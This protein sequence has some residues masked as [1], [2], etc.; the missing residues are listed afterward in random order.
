MRVIFRL[1]SVGIV[2]LVVQTSACGDASGPKFGP[3]ATEV[4]VA[5]N[6]QPNPVVG[7]TLPIPLSIR[8]ADQ[9]DRDVQGATVVWSTSSGTLSAP[10]SRTD[11]KGVASVN[12]TLGTVSGTQTATATVGGLLPVTFIQRS[13]AGAMVQILLSRDTVRL[14][15]V[16]DSFRLNARPVDVY[17]NT[18]LGGSTVESLDTAIVT[19]ENLGSGAILIARAPNATAAV[20]VSAGGLIRIGTVIVLPLPCA[21]SAVP[22]S[23]N[24]GEVAT[25]SGT[26][27]S[28][29][30][31][32]GTVA[33]AEFT[34]I[35]FYSDFS[36]ATLRLSIFAGGTTAASVSGLSSIKRARAPEALRAAAL[37]RDQG[38][39]MKLRDLSKRDLTPK[40]EMARASRVS[41]SGKS[42][43]RALLQLGDQLQ[44]NTN[45]SASCTNAQNRTG[46]VVAISDHAIVIADT[47]NP[48]GGFTDA[49][50]RSFG[51]TFD[52]LVYSVDT[53]NFGEPTD[54]DGNQRVIMFFTSSVNALTPPSLNFF[55][56]GFF[57]GRDLFPTSATPTLE[58]CA[59]S[60]VA[61]MFYLL[62]PD[63]EGTINQNVRSADFVRGITIGVLAHEFQHLINASRHLYVTGST[64]FEDTFLD[65]GLAHMAEELTFY[66]AG[67]LSR[68]QNTAFAATQ[69]PQR[70]LDAFNSFGSAN[71]HRFREFLRDPR[72]SSPYDN[73][74]DISTRGATWA[75]LRY[76][77]D[78]RGGD[79]ITLWHQLANPPAGVH[80]VANLSLAFG[81]GLTSWVRD[82]ATANYA[83]DFISGIQPIYSHPSWNFRSVIPALD[84]IEF[85]LVVQALNTAT[86]TSV[87]II[88]GGA[89][90]LRFAVPAGG[91]GGGRIA[92]RG[93]PVPNGFS[94]SIVRTR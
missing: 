31:V 82:W 75:F 79:E 92:S 29:F 16:G 88:D 32:Q 19:A 57:F 81:S 68:G 15:G 64:T 78:R 24:V 59:T 91:T 42:N 12:W 73:N 45:S 18:V 55:V 49:D 33:G 23:L 54:I 69:S 7:A 74:A 84:A 76:A 53:Q 28:E 17:G 93:G 46:R 72:A 35:P 65:E 34:A 44:L 6:A 37:T 51:D 27:A 60:N 38:F 2:A 20:R 22:L 8:V 58:L 25:L 30:C 13:V 10:S 77:A 3:P 9:Q 47:A 1:R 5:G 67:G 41:G 83:D 4:I 39:E 36:G 40:M 14:L 87:N 89:G 48:A 66:R 52:T 80:G 62:V 56:G 63:P 71:M 85:P 26:A 21:S 43:L 94:L 86:I 90:Y 61:E 50:Y 70:V 11:V